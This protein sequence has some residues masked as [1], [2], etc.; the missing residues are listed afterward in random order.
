MR[1]VE[2]STSHLIAQYSQLLTN[3]GDR[4]LIPIHEKA[5]THRFIVGAGIAHWC[6]LKLKAFSNLVS[7]LWAGN[8]LQLRLCRQQGRRSLNDRHS[9]SETGN[10]AA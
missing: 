9:Q 3:Q 8:A 1:G 4:V 2:N 7:S 10:E 6:Q 5:D